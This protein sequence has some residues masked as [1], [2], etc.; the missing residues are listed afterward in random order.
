MAKKILIID[1]EPNIV[2]SFS[3]L[4]KDEGYLIFSARS[5]EDAKKKIA[6]ITFEL[7]LL[8]MNLPGQSGLEFLKQIK[9]DNYPAEV[10][11]ISGQ[12]E[13]SAALDAIKSGAS[14]Y[15]EKP[16]GPEKLIAAVN[17]VMMLVEAKRQRNVIVD[18]LEAKSKFVG[19]SS[20]FKKLLRNI[21]QVAPSTAAVLI[22]GENGTGKELAATRIYLHSKRRSMPYVKVN[23][24]GIP[25]TLFESELFG[26]KKGSFTGAV[27]DYPGKF[28]TADKGTL[29]LDEIGDLP[30]GCQAKLL[31]VIE[32]GEVETIGETEPKKVDVRLICATNRNL[33]QLISEGK[34]RE[35]LFYRISVFQLELPPLRNRAD[36]IPLLIG[37]F[38]KRYDPSESIKISADGM[39][40][41]AAHDYPGNVRQLKNIIER[42]TILYSGKTVLASDIAI[43]LMGQ[44]INADKKDSAMSFVEKI[45]NFE[46]Q[47]ISKTLSECG[48]NITK[49][50]EV[51][52]VDRANL[53]K[54]IKDFNLKKNEQN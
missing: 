7:I 4:L 19:Q 2:K 12:S 34:F 41:L 50:A 24:P 22:T 1:D 16:V 21:D 27:K 48:G 45:T 25:E 47:L 14:D 36:D 28:V 10:L 20:A 52:G 15:L 33:S 49:T 46:K 37:T 26:H 6:D 8:D 23:C 9:I 11:V 42:L 53:S 39:A 5:S 17:S 18:E 3:S 31:R 38:L 32:N 29:F 35:D 51:L 43:Q 54:K 44:S 30:L 13:I 40:Y